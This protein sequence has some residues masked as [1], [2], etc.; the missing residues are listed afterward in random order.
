MVVVVVVTV[1]VLVVIMITVLM[2]M[3]FVVVVVPP[4]GLWTL[5][6]FVWIRSIMKPN[7]RDNNERGPGGKLVEMDRCA[8]CCMACATSYLVMFEQH[9]MILYGTTARRALSGDET[10]L[11]AQIDRSFDR[12]FVVECPLGAFGAS[13]IG[14]ALLVG[15]TV[16]ATLIDSTT[17]ITALGQTKAGKL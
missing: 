1:V 4:C 12:S 9:D 2:T 15:T 10:F 16:R 17:A 7:G 13:S 8:G 3:P 11:H 14:L 5:L 6:S